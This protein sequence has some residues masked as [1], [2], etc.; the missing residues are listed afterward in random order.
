MSANA[1]AAQPGP[2]QVSTPGLD[3]ETARIERR[4]RFR[5]NTL[6]ALLTVGPVT[7][8]LLAFIAVPLLYILI[9]GFC[10]TDQFYNV[11]YSFT[12]DNFEAMIDPEYLKIYGQSI[13]IALITTVVCLGL[14]Y[15]FSYLISRTFR[16]KKTILYM[17]IIIPFWTNSLI[18][19]YG[20]RT[21]LSASGQL[22]SF[23]MAIGL[24][25]E[26]V[27]FLYNQACTIFGMVYEM[28]PFMVLPLYAA[29]EKLDESQIE[30][31]FDLGANMITTLFRV[32]VPQTMS[33]IF[34]GCIMVFIPSLGAF[35]ISD[36]L[37]GGNADVI[38]NLIQRQFQSAND[39]PLGAALSILLIAITLA[40]V[41]IYQKAGGDMESLGV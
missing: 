23:L 13:V 31:S 29:I 18:R 12:L 17:L 5:S 41:K 36:I 21:F 28:F 3:E 22:N 38:G 25:S 8:W 10:S 27:Q 26:P 32:V 16:S 1:T 33:G 11:V 4:R 35:Y 40:L 2:A 24:A 34:S 20:W 30:A 19:I 14:A 39:W 15:P 37:G 9:M 7:L 6:P